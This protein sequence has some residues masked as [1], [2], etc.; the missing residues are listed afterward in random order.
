MLAAVLVLTIVPA[1]VKIGRAVVEHCC[2]LI[3]QKLLDADDVSSIFSFMVLSHLRLSPFFL[4]IP[5]SGSLRQNIDIGILLRQP[6]STTMCTAS[7]PWFNRI[8]S[9]DGSGCT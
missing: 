6:N 9:E 5:N 3:S 4:D 1:W 8:C 2:F 7:H